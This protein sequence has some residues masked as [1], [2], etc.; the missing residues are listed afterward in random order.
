MREDMANKTME[1]KRQK[2]KRAKRLFPKSYS[3]DYIPVGRG[4]N[5]EVM[6]S[7]KERSRSLAFSPEYL[8]W[9]EDVTRFRGKPP[10]KLEAEQA[11]ERIANAKGK[12]SY[13]LSL[14]LNEMPATWARIK[15]VCPMLMNVVLVDNMRQ[16]VR[17]FWNER[18]DKFI[19]LEL[20]HIGRYMRASMVYQDGER[21]K[22]YFRTNPETVRWVEF[23]S[24]SPPKPND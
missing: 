10:G 15:D 3:A 5:K 11:A 23:V 22:R 20:N 16:H 12:P 6:A 13:Y 14:C 19:L 21:A 9:L 24:S 4:P 1:A 18:R 7:Y 2:M 17:M 8:A